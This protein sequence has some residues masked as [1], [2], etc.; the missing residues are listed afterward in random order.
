MMSIAVGCG[1]AEQA[2]PTTAALSNTTVPLVTASSTTEATTTTTE[3]TTTTVPTIDR[4]A[5][6][7]DARQA[8]GAPGAVAVLR[9]V[10][11]EWSGVSGS[12]DVSGSGLTP[13]TRF[14]VGSITKS[15]VAVLV[16]D[17]VNRGEIS[18]DAEVS[19][20]LPDIFP[21]DPPTS[22]RMLLDHTSGI[23]NVGDEG[24]IR[25]DILELSDPLLQAEATDLGIRYLAGEHVTMPDRLYVALALT[26]ERYFEPGTGYHYSNVNYQLAAMILNRVTGLPLA[27]LLRVRLL[28]PLALRHTTLATDASDLPDMHGYALDPTGGPLIDR[29]DDVLALGNG[30]SGG[31][32]STAGELLTMMQAIVAGDLLPDPL[33]A[34]MKAATHQ[35]NRSYGLGIATYH[36]SCGTFYGHGGAISGTTSIALAATDGDGGVVIAV[37]IQDRNQ[38]DLLPLAESLLCADD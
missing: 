35:S 30:G 20:L 26:H 23:F 22:V 37:N 11:T 13:A 6:L 31:M 21:A 7:D 16:L 33:I 18:L 24:D 4:Q 2:A 1:E 29:T 8:A 10:D 28:E 9:T 34:D 12:A 38:T 5:L 36:L 17:A 3:D 15:I 32:I 27:Q 25:A 19:D 14:R